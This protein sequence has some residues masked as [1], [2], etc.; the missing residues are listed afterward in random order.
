MAFAAEKMERGQRL[1]GRFEIIESVGRGGMGSVYRVLDRT[2][3]E[4]VALKLLNPEI[5]AD[6]KAVERFQNELK[7]ARKITHKY[8]CRMYDIHEAD[9]ALFIT[10]EYVSGED[11]KSLIRRTGFL[12]ALRRRW[13]CA[14]GTRLKMPIWPFGP[15]P[16]S[17]RRDSALAAKQSGGG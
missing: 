17:S 14:D 12:P 8:I 9:G 3:N 11:L 10:M 7:L 15:R 2:I 6:E 16:S 5:A 13:D 4:E 1:A